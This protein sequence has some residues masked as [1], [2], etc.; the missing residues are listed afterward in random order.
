[1]TRQAKTTKHRKNHSLL[2]SSSHPNTAVMTSSTDHVEYK[3]KANLLLL[4]FEDP[5][6]Y[7]WSLC[8]VQLTEVGHLLD[9][10]TPYSSFTSLYRDVALSSLC[11]K[12]SRSTTFGELVETE[13]AESTAP[14]ASLIVA[15]QLGT[16]LAFAKRH[17]SQLLSAGTYSSGVNGAAVI[18]SGLGQIAADAVGCSRTLFEVVTNSIA[19]IDYVV[20]LEQS[21]ERTYDCASFTVRTALQ[22]GMQDSLVEAASSLKV[23]VARSSLNELVFTGKEEDVRTLHGQCQ[24]I[25][26]GPIVPGGMLIGMQPRKGLQLPPRPSFYAQRASTDSNVRVQLSPLAHQRGELTGVEFYEQQKDQA[27]KGVDHLMHI[28]RLVHAPAIL[29]DSVSG[30]VDIIS[31]GPE[32]AFEATLSGRL[33]NLEAQVRSIDLFASLLGAA[34]YTDIDALPTRYSLVDC[35]PQT[36]VAIIGYS[37][38]IPGASDPDEFWDLLSQG[39]DMHSEIPKQIFDL[40]LYHNNQYRVPNTMRTRHGNFLAHPG[41]FD[42]GLFGVTRSQALQMDPQHR[43]AFLAAFEALEM[44]G[45]S[46]MSSRGANSEYQDTGV[47]IGGAGDDYRENCSWTIEDDFIMGNSRQALTANISNFFGFHGPSHTYDTACSSSLVAVEAACQSL[48]NGRCSTALAGGVSVLTQPQV[49]IGLDRGYFLTKNEHG[50]CQTYDDGGD[51]YSRADGNA[52]LHLKLLKDALRDGDDVKGTIEAIGTNHSGKSHSITHPHAPTQ[53]RLFE[54]NCHSAKVD[55]RRIDLVEMHGT[56]TQAGDANEMQS[57]LSFVR[58]RQDTDNDLI[59]GSVKANLGHSEAASGCVALIKVLLSLKHRQ[60]TPHVGIKKKL[61]TKFPPLDRVIIP[62]DLK[63]FEVAETQDILACCNNFSAAG[64]NSSLII[65]SFPVLE[66]LPLPSLQPRILALSAASVAALRSYLERLSS[67]VEQNPDKDILDIA[68]TL[69]ATRGTQFS[70]RVALVADST[71]ALKETLAGDVTSLITEPSVQ[72][73]PGFAFAF[74]GQ[75]SQ[76]VEMGKELYDG[77]TVFREA[78]DKTRAIL[79]AQGFPDF[80][81]EVYAETKQSKALPYHW[82]CAI[83]AVEIALCRLWERLGITPQVVVGHSLGEYAALHAAGVLSWEDAVF[84]VASRAKL[85]STKLEANTSAMLAVRL[86]AADLAQVIS[87]QS[88]SSSL[89]VACI[90]SPTD[91]VLAGPLAEVQMAHA[92]L[93]TDAKQQC[94]LVDVPYAFHSQAVE[95]IMKDFH[96]VAAQVKFRPPAVTL[97]SNVLGRALKAG[98]TD[99][100]WPDYLVRHMRETVQF[101]SSIHDLMAR[102][103]GGTLRWIEI[104]PH[105]LCTPMLATSL[106]SSSIPRALPSLRRKTNGLNTF[107]ESVGALHREGFKVDFTGLFAETVCPPQVLD[108]PLYAWQYEDYWIRYTDRSL[109]TRLKEEQAQTPEKGAR[110]TKSSK[111]GAA[112]GGSGGLATEFALL[113]RCHSLATETNPVATYEIDLTQSPC[114]EIVEGHLVHDVCLVPAS[115]YSDVALQAGLHVLSSVGQTFDENKYALRVSDIL[116]DE[117]VVLGIHD[118]ITIRT[119]GLP[120]S[121]EGMAIEFFFASGKRQGSCKV[122]LPPREQVENRW[123]GIGGVLHRRIGALTA[124][125][126]VA[127]KL[128]TDMIYRLFTKV[129][130]YGSMYRAMQS[131]SLNTAG[132]EAALDVTF[133]QSPC[134]SY[135]Q[136]R[137]VV[138][139]VFQDSMGQCTGFLPNLQADADHVYVANG[140]KVIEYTSQMLKVAKSGNRVSVHCSMQEDQGMSTSD[141]YFFDQETGAVIGHMGGVQFRKIPLRVMKHLLPK[142]KSS[143]AKANQSKAPTS[144]HRSEE[145]K[146]AV[147]H[148]MEFSPPSPDEKSSSASP[149][150]TDAPYDSAFSSESDTSLFSQLCRAIVEELAV[151]ESELTHDRVLADL[152][153]DS[154]MSLTILAR[155]QE[156]AEVELPASLFMDHPTLGSVQAYFQDHV[157]STTPA[158]SPESSP[159]CIKPTHSSSSSSP[160]TTPLLPSSKATQPIKSLETHIVVLQ[161]AEGTAAKEHPVLLVPDGSGS[162]DVY[163]P[164]VGATK[165]CFGG[166]RVLSASFRSVSSD[167]TLEELIESIGTAAKRVLGNQ[168]CVIGG[169]KQDWKTIGFRITEC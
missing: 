28:A 1:M 92:F 10:F 109:S 117:P 56:G 106:D 168:R 103:E 8:H 88:F 99:I 47:F 141:A 166:R 150:D 64:G 85:M 153:L 143:E 121:N 144:T 4:A 17:H 165:P 162:Q 15:L 101:A 157:E 134:L 34:S 105:P 161:E 97:L 70:A 94:T 24:T 59:I 118:H 128:T 148:S 20:A 9:R 12:A 91:T 98:E 48:V 159:A 78:M 81:D 95:P 149:S 25:G 130:H 167:W 129:V 58:G 119:N 61:N 38:R 67:Y 96:N 122:Q 133:Q 49:Y 132:T 71:A 139:P 35:H 76:Y 5:E 89:Q 82:Q 30:L 84:L 51:G 107:L 52:V 142:P 11:R 104:G 108:L 36:Q 80:F 123:A 69:S 27:R 151:A 16:Y 111:G 57:V 112:D 115:M 2:H 160:G 79:V 32:R 120:Q 146:R 19:V 50:Q 136:R 110:R 65:R 62:K 42:A 147:A 145:P 126:G 37:L 83:L 31:I 13:L 77:N 55:P 43:N 53:A 90:N 60:A 114:R 46:P 86:S 124:G 152:G 93:K 169:K 154:L 54:A 135:E 138:F 102:H 22:D 74:T 3:D 72:R 131:V 23:S 163:A 18:S 26:S 63:A 66:D 75:G 100:C 45:Y 140:C 137:F 7:Q 125:Y 41:R 33:K 40:D 68:Y 73:D 158:T 156:T 127:T 29:T 116:M 21:L 14:R 113:T 155:L 44:S 164:L 6:A 87:K 39:R